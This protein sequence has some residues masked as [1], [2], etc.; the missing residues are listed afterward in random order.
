MKKVVL[1]IGG[2]S[3]SACSNSLEKFLK[4]QDGIIDAS[5]NLVMASA[6]ITYDDKLKLSDVEALVNKSGFKSQGLFKFE[7]DKLEKTKLIILIGYAILSVILLYITMGHM[8]GLPFFE[9]FSPHKNPV[10]FGILCLIFVIPYLIYGFEIFKNGIKNIFYLSPN[11]DTLVTIGVIASFTYSLV[12]LIFLIQGKA[13]NTD[14]LYFESCCI[15]IFFVKMGRFIDYKIKNK[16]KSAIN[17]LVQI[18]PEKAKIKNDNGYEEI[19]IDL[20]NI[21]DTLVASTGDKIAVDGIVSLGECYVDEAFLTG[22]SKPVK[23][24][25][26]DKVIAGSIIHNGYIEYLAKRIGKDSTI[27]EIVH[28]VVDA[29][30]TKAK[31]SRVADKVS[32]IF[33]P[34]IIG[35]ALISFVIYLIVTKSFS[36]SINIFVC[37]LVVACP[38]ALGLATP[39][40]IVTSTGVL[41]KL[42]ILI[43]KS[44]ILEVACK[45]DTIVFDKTGT[46]TYGKLKISEKIT[47]IDSLIEDVALI[48]SKSNHPISS[49]F[50]EYIKN[51]EVQNFKTYEGMGISGE[52]DGRTIYLGNRKLVESLNIKNDHIDDEERLANNG[53]TIIYCIMNQEI[54]ELYGIKD[55]VRDNVQELIKELKEL[56]IESVMLT[57]DNDAV[58]NIVGNSIGIDKVISNV[59]PKDKAQYI[60]ELT[61]N[62]KHVM[63]VGDGINDAPSL[64]QATVGVSVHSGTSI[65][66]DASDVILMKDDLSRIIDLIKISKKTILNIKENLFWAFFYNILM[67]PIALGALLPLGIKLNPMI[68]G[69][70]M[71]LS[72]ICV[73]LNALR[74]LKYKKKKE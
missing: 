9:L 28:L 67:I 54:Y 49:A 61:D 41:A 27:S 26:G 36:T 73:L 55:T 16:T 5:V 71:T 68:A 2:M 18:T 52:I 17:D 25:K 72:S 47:Y 44:S 21:D 43:K 65:A 64:A 58:A 32:S 42:G 11:M 48:E 14:G 63:M 62:N 45:I 3:C 12:N 40:A 10:N 53:N 70:G 46:L 6:N 74:L 50:K 38:C 66:A 51:N 22:E 57:G 33:V 29:T 30:N 1:K 24:R 8:I 31:I 15:I 35:I 19:T 23:K 34:S 60:K 4:R 69:I 37:I 59:M 20:V 7:S 56:K 39:L 13:N